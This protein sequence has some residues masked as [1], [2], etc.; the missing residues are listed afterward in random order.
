MDKISS[1]KYI[2]RLIETLLCPPVEVPSLQNWVSGE[3]KPVERR[4]DGKKHLSEP[5]TFSDSER[6]ALTS[7]LRDI[8][9]TFEDTS[10]I[11][12]VG[13]TPTPQGFTPKAQFR[14]IF[15]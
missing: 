5:M 1:G 9:S 11:I 2:S 15:Y 8:Y 13:Q 14:C 4:K 3:A 7:T 12:T 6:D 10:H